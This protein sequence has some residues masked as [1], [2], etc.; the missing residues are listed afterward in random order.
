MTATS[1]QSN[2]MTATANNMTQADHITAETLEAILQAPTIFEL[3]D[4]MLSLPIDIPAFHS[5]MHA[6]A[7]TD[8]RPSPVEARQ[9]IT[10]ALQACA[11]PGR[12]VNA[13]FADLIDKAIKMLGQLRAE[14]AEECAALLEDL[15][16]AVAADDDVNLTV[17]LGMAPFSASA[18]AER[19]RE[20][21]DAA[22]PGELNDPDRLR[23]VQLQALQDAASAPMN[24]ELAGAIMDA[25]NAWASLRAE[26]PEAKAIRQAFAEARRLIDRHGEDDPRAFAAIV[27]AVNLQDPGFMDAKLTECGIHLPKP[28]RCTDDGMPLY[29][30]EALAAALD[31]DLGDL[32]EH[33]RELEAL[34]IGGVVR[35]AG[36]DLH[37]LQ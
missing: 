17:A 24:D 26:T 19:L 5:H 3:E 22:V 31:A 34:G 33:A 13:M 11:L 32:E 16:E 28:D 12:I 15:R 29:S 35:V 37:T 21:A 4:A 25:L 36:D 14:H 27:K 9:A 2:A 20:L 7:A 23:A 8:P 6:I 18:Y 30:L 10:E 1:N